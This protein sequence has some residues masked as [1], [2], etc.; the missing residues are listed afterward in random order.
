MTPQP[1]PARRRVGRPRPRSRASTSSTRSRG[2]T[3]TPSPDWPSASAPHRRGGGTRASA[4]RSRSSWRPRWHARSGP[5]D[6][7][8]ALITGAEALATVRR[9]KKAGEKPQWSFRRRRSG[10]F[11]MDMEFDP[12]EITPRRLRG[13]PDV[14]PVRQRPA[15]PPGPRP[16]RAPGAAR[17]GA[18]PHDGDRGRQPARLVPRG[19]QRRRD[20][21]GHAGQPDGGLPL[22]EADDVDHGRRHGGRAAS[23]PAPPRP[24][25][26]ASPRR[27]AG[28]PARRGLRRGPR[29]RGGPS[30]AVALPRHGRRGR[31]GTGRCRHRRRRRRP[32][33]PLLVLRQLG[34]LR[35]RRA[36]DQRGRR[37]RRDPDGRVAV[38]RWARLQLHDPRAGRHG[39]DAPPRARLLRRDQRCRHAHAEARLRRVVDRSRRRRPRR[40]RT[41][42]A[43][44]RTARPS[45]SRPRARPPSPPTRSCTVGMA[46]PSARC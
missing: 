28:L 20:R 11:P 39:R 7:D 35:P 46:D 14:R 16:R 27:T 32:P 40:R 9:L 30:R 44:A 38:P 13:L 42:A 22:H 33:R 36:G 34:V 18:G 8:L 15:G 19:P 4:D 31:R 17:A 2:S 43:G 6:L 12:S 37:P 23:W 41:S 1:T 25:R 5:G 29:A 21:D 45:S 3:T 10:R 24:T 26:W